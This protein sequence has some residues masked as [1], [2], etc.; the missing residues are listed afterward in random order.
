MTLEFKRDTMAEAIAACCAYLTLDSRP[1]PLDDARVYMLIGYAHPLSNVRLIAAHN[2]LQ[3]PLMGF[4]TFNL[5]AVDIEFRER[6]RKVLHVCDGAGWCC[7]NVMPGVEP[8]CQYWPDLGG[9][10][11]KGDGHKGG[12]SVDDDHTGDMT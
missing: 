12:C 10:C 4:A 3:D 6:N 9:Y 8:C 1:G 2:G 7:S 11:V 5:T